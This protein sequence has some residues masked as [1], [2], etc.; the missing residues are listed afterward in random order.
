MKVSKQHIASEWDEG[1]P[2]DGGDGYW[3]R[4]KPGWKW[5]GDSMGAV[6]CIHEA[7]RKKAHSEGVMKCN[8]DG[9]NGATT[10]A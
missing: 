9:C 1:H 10:Q 3:I 5:S 4:L 2:D 8:C 7:T 6:H